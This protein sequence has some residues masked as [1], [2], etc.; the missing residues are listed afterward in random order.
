[1]RSEVIQNV[2][3]HQALQ[4]LEVSSTLKAVSEGLGCSCYF[5]TNI[6][7]C[8]FFSHSILLGLSYNNLIL[9]GNALDCHEMSL[10]ML[11]K[12]SLVVA[13]SW[14]KPATVCNHGMPLEAEVLTSASNEIGRAHV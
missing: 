1:M 14:C 5:V 2:Q 11:K 4:A 13:N 6:H 8:D 10:K 12:E 9:C 3:R 7:V